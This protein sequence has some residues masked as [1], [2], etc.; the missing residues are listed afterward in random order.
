MFQ[1]FLHFNSLVQTQF[2]AK[3]KALRSDGGG[4]FVNNNFKSF[5]LEH[6]IQHQ[7]SCPYF[8]QQNGIA[9]RKH[10]QI[11]ESGLSILHHSNLSL[12]Y[13][14]Y[15]FCTTV[16]LL[17]RGPSSV[18]NFISP[19][20]K[21][22]DHKPPLHALKTFGCACYPFLKPYNS[23]KFDPK[24]RQCIFLGYPPQSKG[25]ICLDILTSRIYIS[26]HCVF[27]ESVF[28]LYPI[29]NSKS[30]STVSA[31]SSPSFDV[32]L[33]SLLPNSTLGLSQSSSSTP[34]GPA[35]S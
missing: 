1:V 9:E 33:S 35:L 11:V 26:C 28:P 3:I 14:S 20:E 13:W 12:S 17:N 5:C 16:Y 25:Y 7:L 23:H 19:W 29:P 2:N 32:C 18:L 4:E 31:T 34:S 10:R 6:G 24:S 27:D 8:P 15:A 30:T 21:L 22:Y